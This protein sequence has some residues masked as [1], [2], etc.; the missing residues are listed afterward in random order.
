MKLKITD[1]SIQ[2]R[3]RA[4]ELLNEERFKF[5]MA[6]K[7]KQVHKE[8]SMFEGKVETRAIKDYDYNK[9]R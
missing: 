6:Q 5:Q 8:I 9:T 7:M 2:D 4:E 3:K 1:F